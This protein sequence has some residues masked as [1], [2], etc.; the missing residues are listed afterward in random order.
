MTIKQDRITLRKLQ[1]AS[2][3][4]EETLC[5]TAIVLFDGN[6]IATARNQGHGGATWFHALKGQGE[7]LGEAEAFAKTLPPL[8]IKESDHDGPDRATELSV[9]LELLVDHLAN[10]MQVETTFN[11]DFNNKAMFVKDRRLRYVKGIRLRQVQSRGALFDHLRSHFGA[12]VVLNELS[13]EEAFELWKR[14][15]GGA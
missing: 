15:T 11:R 9:D 7:K 4:S 8:R 3:A 5:F 14:Y 12:E 6:P 13:R 1:V 10:D 2:F